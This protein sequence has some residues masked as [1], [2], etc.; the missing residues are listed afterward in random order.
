LVF[1]QVV[2]KYAGYLDHSKENPDGDNDG[3]LGFLDLD[4]GSAFE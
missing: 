1:G 4:G 2:N 3:L